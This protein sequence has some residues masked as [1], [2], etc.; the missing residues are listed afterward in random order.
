MFRDSSYVHTSGFCTT[1]LVGLVALTQYYMSDENKD[2][3]KK[4]G[5]TTVEGAQTA[6][7]PKKEE[8]AE[9]HA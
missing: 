2:G 1:Y 8:T 4:D 7:V 3:V 5:A 6:T 9:K